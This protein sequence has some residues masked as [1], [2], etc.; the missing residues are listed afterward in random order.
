MDGAWYGSY[1]P[2]NRA[3]RAKILVERIEALNAASEW[4]G[5]MPEQ[6]WTGMGRAEAFAVRC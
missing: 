1:Q 2:S 3:I 6:L 5:C 4:T